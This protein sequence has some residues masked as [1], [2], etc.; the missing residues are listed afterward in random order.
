MNNII[1]TQPEYLFHLL[2]SLKNVYYVLYY[3]LVISSRAAFCICHWVATVWDVGLQITAP[4]NSCG[5]V[6]EQIQSE[7]Q[8]CT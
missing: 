6:K 1:P 2:A 8:L 3:V 7:F 4:G 5:T